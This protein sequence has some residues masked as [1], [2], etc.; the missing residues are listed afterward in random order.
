MI[1]N[2]VKLLYIIILC[3]VV[4]SAGHYVGWKIAE[5]QETVFLSTIWNQAYVQGRQTERFLLIQGMEMSKAES[6]EVSFAKIDST[7]YDLESKK[8]D[9]IMKKIRIHRI[10]MVHC[11]M[12]RQ[13][14]PAE[15][16]ADC[17]HE[18]T[19]TPGI[20][21]RCDFDEEEAKGEK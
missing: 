1:P 15:S 11:P 12:A 21:V 20:E 10:P 2:K 14:I 16:C 8:G 5:R 9:E 6:L 13:N 19:I 7:C 3:F 4:F 17:R 18:R